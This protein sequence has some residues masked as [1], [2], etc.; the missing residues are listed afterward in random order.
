[1]RLYDAPER[2][3]APFE[4]SHSPQPFS[5][6][7]RWI[8][9]NLHQL[10]EHGARLRAKQAGRSFVT[11]HI[12]P[13]RTCSAGSACTNRFFRRAERQFQMANER[14][15]DRRDT[16][17]YARRCTSPVAASQSQSMSAVS[18]YEREV[19]PEAFRLDRADHRERLAKDAE[20]ASKTAQICPS[21]GKF[22]NRPQLALTCNAFLV[23]C[24]SQ[25]I[26]NFT[27]RR[28]E[29]LNHQIRYS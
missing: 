13:R 6:F 11:I 24:A 17:I 10:F 16:V 2:N 18:R 1:M 14:L 19:V 7:G 22:G 28:G 27:A 8:S 29:L 25:S 21:S 9:H 26:A 4:L 5:C 12:C 15:I 3:Q 23:V 20:A